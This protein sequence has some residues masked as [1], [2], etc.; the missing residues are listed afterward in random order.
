M[1]EIAAALP[2]PSCSLKAESKNFKYLI[3][4]SSPLARVRARGE[5]GGPRFY[6]GMTS[7][8]SIFWLSRTTRRSIKR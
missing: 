4:I 1:P 2:A 7:N 8:V 6:S 5:R 3:L